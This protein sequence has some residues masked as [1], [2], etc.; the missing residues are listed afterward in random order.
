MNYLL[1]RLK[2][3]Y[4]N[5]I[6]VLFKFKLFFFVSILFLGLYSFVGLTQHR[7][8][9]LHKVLSPFCLRVL[10]A[11]VSI[12]IFF[13]GFGHFY[14]LYFQNTSRPF[15][16]IYANPTVWL[17]TFCHKIALKCQPFYIFLSG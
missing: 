2:I 13:F 7:I 3:N 6:I 12:I 17:Y 4:F 1:L 14:L 11:Q 10:I 5:P 9:Q 15:V 16:R 8:T